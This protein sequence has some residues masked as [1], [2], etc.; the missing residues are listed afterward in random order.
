MILSI[1]KFFCMLLFLALPTAMTIY[2]QTITPQRLVFSR[3]CAGN[4]NG[5]DATFNHSGF[6]AGTEFEVQLS[7]P[8]G[9]F[10]NPTA[11]SIVATTTI[12]SSQK[13]IRFAIPSS[14]VGSENYRLRIKSSTGFLS[15]PFLN[16]ASNNSF[17][18]YYKSFE[19]SFSI[20]KK[21][22]T[23]SLCPGGIIAIPIDNTT[24]TIPASSPLNY[25]NLKYKWY[26][27]NVVIPG[28]SSSTLS[29][30]GVGTYFAE[31][32]YGSCS[33]ANFSSNR[34]TITPAAITTA[35][36][37]SS[38]GNT[39]CTAN[40]TT[41]LSTQ[42]GN[43]YQWFRDNVA[44]SGATNPTFETNQAGN[45]A[46]NV[47]FGGCESKAS[48][49]LKSISIQGSLN[50]SSPIQ[51]V[52]NTTTTVSV[53]SDSV[54][55]IYAWFKNDNPITNATSNSLVL[56]EEGNYKV[57]L[58]HPTCPVSAEIP[59]EVQFSI[60]PNIKEIPNLITPNNDGFNDTWQLPL[61]YTAGNNVEV[62][63]VSPIGEEVLRTKEYKNDW[64]ESSASLKTS[65]SVYYYWITSPNES[66][67]KGS[68][69]LIR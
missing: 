49:D 46:V 17:P 6:A 34:V 16:A 48:M 36:I 9:S 27:N 62:V 15:A 57:K 59:F 66:V 68:I 28:A 29:A 25:S 47:N 33:D 30:S 58:T 24:P 2:A 31:I 18:V 23:A 39:F 3:I 26:Q 5:F 4:F 64:P 52:P 21:E 55:P 65:H 13:R 51:L 60:D 42:K 44:L 7:D 1:N 20:N 43:S 37:V 61:Q 14:L 54:D 19:N 12:S 8:N 53:S 41:V 67:K 40:L 50:E 45:Y 35:T 38:Q 32:D 11:T 56:S 10:D 69:T 63:I 22:N